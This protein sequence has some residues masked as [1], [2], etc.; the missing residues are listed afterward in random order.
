MRCTCC[1]SR[2]VVRPGASGFRSQLCLICFC[3][4]R[5]IWQATSAL[6]GTPQKIEIMRL[7]W[8]HLLPLHHPDDWKM[9]CETTGVRMREEAELLRV[10]RLAQEADEELELIGCGRDGRQVLRFGPEDV[11]AR[12]PGERD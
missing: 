1:N 8:A 3:R 6:P 7:R 2:P 5:E 11:E 12:L 4:R 9:N 10:S